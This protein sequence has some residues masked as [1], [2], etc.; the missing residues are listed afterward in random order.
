M[1]KPPRT[2]VRQ[3]SLREKEIAKLK[4]SKQSGKRQARLE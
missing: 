3:M 2:Q 1:D 4:A